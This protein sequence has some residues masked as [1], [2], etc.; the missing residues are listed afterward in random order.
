MLVI[1]GSL[2]GSWLVITETRADSS[3]AINT[4]VSASNLEYQVH[5][6]E[7]SANAL[8]GAPASQALNKTLLSGVSGVRLAE[9]KWTAS[10]SLHVGVNQYLATVDQFESL[11]S[12]G[13]GSEAAAFEENTLQPVSSAIEFR[14]ASDAGNKLKVAQASTV[15]AND[16]SDA[17]RWGS[18]ALLAVLMG[19][20]WFFHLKGE[21]EKR[22]II[23]KQERR[24]RTMID[25]GGD[26]FLL[27]DWDG[28]IIFSNDSSQQ[29]LCTSTALHV[30]TLLSEVAADVGQ[31]ELLDIFSLVRDYPEKS[32]TESMVV[33][34]DEPR[35]IEVT[36]TSQLH[37]P[38]VLAVV[39]NVRDITERR[40]TKAALERSDRLLSDLIHHAP[41]L[42]YI[43]D[44]DGRYT[45]VNSAFLKAT[46]MSEADVLGTT[47]AALFRPEDAKL[48][49]TGDNQALYSGAYEAEEEILVNG[50]LRVF[51][52]SRFPLLDEL[53]VP[54]AVAGV[55]IDITDRIRLQEVEQ[56][57]NA[58][59]IYGLDALVDSKD[60]LI[61]RWNPA[62]ESMFGYSAEEI[63]GKPV[64]VLVVDS[65]NESVLAIITRLSAGEIVQG[66]ELVGLRKDGTTFIGSLTAVP[67]RDSGGSQL[68][69]SSIIHDISREHH[70]GNDVL[71]LARLDPLTGLAN[72]A[73]L[74]EQLSSLL[75]AHDKSDVTEG[76]PPVL[77]MIG[78]DRFKAI[79]AALGQDIGDRL[80][81]LVAER[82]KS[83][84]S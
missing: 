1:V 5:F 64:S 27:V 55:S 48:I 79:N 36:A 39:L 68:G 19:L 14:L 76:D 25:Q 15:Y 12:A 82:I 32:L 69:V 54:Y 8:A 10:T 49:A 52:T 47:S 56:R 30:G 77:V 74:I 33:G 75:L 51:L 18:L 38:T 31:P 84:T 24:F 73:S 81:Q 58:A 16:W 78:M 21:I 67:L 20:L 23:E 61:S 41:V 43:K 13:Q 46:A 80:L 29:I 44:L 7:V 72:R 45:R 63:I 65:E 57:L 53:E 50:N 17:T 2:V 60:G 83:I 28:V 70:R 71:A 3:E 59:T 42:I 35:I 4:A 9:S 66:V 6:V 22:K 37:D 62:A 11:I 40:L 26:A 34:A